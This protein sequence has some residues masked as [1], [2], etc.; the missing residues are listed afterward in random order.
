MEASEW[1]GLTARLMDAIADRGPGFR[2]I[3]YEG[4]TYRSKDPG[5]YRYAEG[6]ASRD[7]GILDP[8]DMLAAYLTA[9]ATQLPGMLRRG[10]SLARPPTPRSFSPEAE[11]LM[12]EIDA[13]LDTVRSNRAFRR[14]A[15]QTP[16]A[17]IRELR[18][19]SLRMNPE[20]YTAGPGYDSP[21]VPSTFSAHLPSSGK[22]DDVVAR[23]LDAGNLSAEEMQRLVDYLQRSGGF[24][25]LPTPPLERPV[26]YYQI[27]AEQPMHE[28]VRSGKE[29]ILADL[30]EQLGSV[31]HDPEFGENT[32]RMIQWLLQERTH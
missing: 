8:V 7:T 18:D 14:A 9:G 4:A 15:T 29:A 3:P 22:A 11:G 21:H 1:E 30:L 6:E 2:G 20:T 17:R 24:Q 10:A 5:S 12:G 25:R 31:K 32:L 13:I 27:P 23:M 19:P 26:P 16:E 28:T